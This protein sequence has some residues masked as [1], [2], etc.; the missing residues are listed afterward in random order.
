[1]SVVWDQVPGASSYT[2]TGMSQAKVST[3]DSFLKIDAYNAQEDYNFCIAAVHGSLSSA[4]CTSVAIPANVSKVKAVSVT[5]SLADGVYKSGTVIPIAVKFSGKVSLAPNANLSLQLKHGV[6]E[7]LVPYTSGSS[8][9]TLVFSYTVRSG[10]DAASL[11]AVGLFSA[12]SSK[13]LL[14]EGGRPLLY[15]LPAAPRGKSLAEQKHLQIDTLAPAPPSAVSFTSPISATLSFDVNWLAGSDANLSGYRSKV[16]S[17]SACSLACSTASALSPSL[18]ATKSGVDGASYFA[19][20]Q[21]EDLAANTSA[22]VSSIAAVT[23]QTSAP[24][25]S[26]VTSPTANGFFKLGDVIP[27]QVIYSSNV[28]VTNGNDFGLTL[29]TGTIDRNALYSAGSGTNTL[30]FLYTIQAGDTA[31]D[32][33]SCG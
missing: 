4:S 28:Y 26:S 9:D 20:V 21:A 33:R 12:D 11:D 16:C 13:G 24:L 10:H 27:I 3:S 30:T 15:N 22:W 2:I 23:V 18:T 1:M 32:L 7:S 5:S 6:T 25:V 8:S 17:D 14:D 29:E 31:S 19:C